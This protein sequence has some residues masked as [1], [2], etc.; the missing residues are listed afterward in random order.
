[1]TIIVHSNR[2]LAARPSKHPP[3]PAQIPDQAGH[4][5]APMGPYPQRQQGWGDPCSLPPPRLPPHSL[6]SIS[7]VSYPGAGQSVI[8]PRLGDTP[9]RAGMAD[10]MRVGLKSRRMVLGCGALFDADRVCFRPSLTTVAGARWRL[11]VEFASSSGTV[12]RRWIRMICFGI[13]RYLLCRTMAQFGLGV[14]LAGRQENG[15]GALLAHVGRQ[16]TS[17]D[18]ASLASD[19][20]LKIHKSRQD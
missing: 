20:L 19:L 1:M 3:R 14:S 13:R 12:I 9:A 6:K 10:A 16:G 18:L 7:G 15:S 11:A 2:C 8:L 4:V 17:E 5:R